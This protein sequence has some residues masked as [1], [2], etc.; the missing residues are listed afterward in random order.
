[1]V[2]IQS[3]VLKIHWRPGQEPGQESN[4]ET[5]ARKLRYRSLAEASIDQDIKSLF[6]GHHLSDQIETIIIRLLRG[7]IIA[8]PGL[9]GM[10]PLNNIP[11]CENIFG[12]S[13]G[14]EASSLSDLFDA[15]MAPLTSTE[16]SETFS[17]PS[18]ATGA[19]PIPGH[20]LIPHHG[21]KIYRPLLSFPKTRLIA[22][23]EVN[24]VPFV[25]DPSNLDPKITV[26][27]TV[28]WLISKKKMPM[29]LR[30]EPILRLAAFSARLA[31]ALTKKCI[32]LLKVTQLVRFDLRSGRLIVHIPM[33]ICNE[34]NAS[35]NEAAYFLSQL[36]GLV[37]PI[38]GQAQSYLRLVNFA[39][40]MF[41]ELRDGSSSIHDKDLLLRTFTALDVTIE[42]KGDASD[43]LWEVYRR[44]F[45]AGEHQHGVF[46]PAPFHSKG[47]DKTWS[48]WTAWDG[49]YWIRIRTRNPQD[50]QKYSLRAL[51]QPDMAEINAG[52]KRLS[53]KSQQGLYALKV[54][55]PG[56]RRYTLP[57]ILKGH[58][59]RVIP[60]FDI[61]FPPMGSVRNTKSSMELVDE[62]Q[63]EVRY[64][65][66]TETL[67]HLKISA[68]DID[69]LPKLGFSPA[70]KSLLS[71][72]SQPDD[73]E[74]AIQDSGRLKASS[75]LSR[76]I[77]QNSE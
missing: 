5:F 46:F 56:K 67:Q 9:A 50:V 22:T 2:G 47:I 32:E 3:K 63:W 54:A 7:Q 42:R 73:H 53:K 61:E 6:L 52:R 24:N 8:S 37:A 75:C 4:F 29:A 40:W 16:T 66:V 13:V 23:C 12:A 64:K 15:Q 33:D 70:S 59:A 11:C 36:L 62:L 69:K 34:Y 1:M 51:Q 71:S 43:C 38:R 35:E 49:R 14:L 17:A 57:V 45:K 31:E 77:I 20:I 68:S 72:S 27:N 65:G 39:R 10:K 25:T 26:R 74:D 76:D 58:E 21:I 19:G 41:P 55:A 60:T 28:R 18:P 30:Q 44:P 48:E